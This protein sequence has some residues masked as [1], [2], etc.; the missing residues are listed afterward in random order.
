MAMRMRTSRPRR[1]KERGFHSKLRFKERKTKAWEGPLVD[2]KEID[3][4]KKLL[5]GSSKMMSR[6]R[7]GTSAKEQ[8]AVKQ[9]VK[10]AR[11]IALIP[12]KGL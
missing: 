2:Y 1:K 8:R 9:A 5:T 4:L 10:R 12:Y 3:L 6:K 7:A 11:F